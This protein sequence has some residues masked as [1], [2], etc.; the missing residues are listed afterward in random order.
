MWCNFPIFFSFSASKRAHPCPP[1]VSIQQLNVT[2]APS[3]LR[4]VEIDLKPM[5][6]AKNQINLWEWWRNQKIWNAVSETHAGS[7]LCPYAH[8]ISSK[9]YVSGLVNPPLPLSEGHQ[10]IFCLNIFDFAPLTREQRP[11]TGVTVACDVPR[12]HRMGWITWR[13]WFR[14]VVSANSLVGCVKEQE[15]CE[16]SHTTK[17]RPE[18]T[19]YNIKKKIMGQKFIW[20]IELLQRGLPTPKLTKAGNQIPGRRFLIGYVLQQTGHQGSNTNPA[21]WS[22]FVF[23]KTRAEQILCRPQQVVKYVNICSEMSM[24]D[25]AGSCQYHASLRKLISHGQTK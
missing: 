23:P 5:D 8:W 4:L 22:D 21:K 14:P 18:H 24:A 6:K 13:I 9:R 3:P 1:K 16:P 2:Y 25:A 10:I 7:E 15:V 20:D 17:V 11:A 19:S 12:T